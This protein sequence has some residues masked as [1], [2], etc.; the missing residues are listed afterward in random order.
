MKAGSLNAAKGRLSEAAARCL[1]GDRGAIHAAVEELAEVTAL[2]A[3]IKAKAEASAP[4]KAE[5]RQ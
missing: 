1:A 4:A 3:V 5:S 2:L